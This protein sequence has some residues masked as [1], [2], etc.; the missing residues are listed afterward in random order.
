MY[1]GNPV[2]PAQQPQPNQGQYVG[3]Q[4]EAMHVGAAQHN[5][6]LGH[7]GR[8]E[9]KPP[10]TMYAVFV[11]ESNDKQSKHRRHMEV[12]AVMPAVPRFMYGSAAA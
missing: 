3:N 2:M 10:D 7:T 8:N 6:N 1:V 4:G 5:P 11:T 9:Y 12:N